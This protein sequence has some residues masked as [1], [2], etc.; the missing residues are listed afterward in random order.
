MEASIPPWDE[1]DDGIRETVRALWQ[2]NF[3]PVDSGDGSKVGKMECAL[4]MPHVILRCDPAFLFE[5]A[6]RL[7]RLVKTWPR[8]GTYDGN[9]IEA[10]YCP[11]DGIGLIGLY[12]VVAP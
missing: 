12:G 1:L 3:S 5:E 4:D 2:A 6:N 9:A 11:S 7:H 8:V 10:S